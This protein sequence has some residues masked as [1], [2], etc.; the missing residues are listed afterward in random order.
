M[1]AIKYFLLLLPAPYKVSRFRVCF[2]FQPLSSKY[3]CFHKNL[4]ASTSL[5]HGLLKM[6]LLSAPQLVKCFRVRFRFQLLSSKCFRFSKNLTAYTASASLVQIKDIKRYIK[7]LTSDVT[8]PCIRPTTCI[9][10]WYKHV[11]ANNGYV[12]LW[13]ILATEK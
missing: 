1:E 13:I 12:G 4:T 10:F 8:F 7:F 6:L 3:F 9:W 2:R 5:P 11:S